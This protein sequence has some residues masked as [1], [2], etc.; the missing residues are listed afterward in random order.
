VSS[1]TKDWT[2]ASTKRLTAAEMAWRNKRI[3]LMAQIEMTWE[4]IAAI[5]HVSVS[6]A[7]RAAREWQEYL[8]RHG[9]GNPP[10]PNSGRLVPRLKD[11]GGAFGLGT[12]IDPEEAE[13]ERQLV[14]ETTR[15]RA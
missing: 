10:H 6:T 8:N 5:E 9:E 11:G 2:G 15:R 4:E 13:I 7:R 12:P 1:D 14:E 3:W